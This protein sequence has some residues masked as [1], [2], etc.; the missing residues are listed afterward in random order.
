MESKSEFRAFNATMSIETH[1]DSYSFSEN[2]IATSGSDYTCDYLAAKGFYR[3][4][5]TINSGDK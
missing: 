1:S 5:I 2:V 4:R 3:Q